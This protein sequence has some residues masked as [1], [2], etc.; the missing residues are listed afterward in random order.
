MHILFPYLHVP[1]LAPNR[2]HGTPPSLLSATLITPTT[3]HHN[4]H[5]QHNHHNNH[6]PNHDLISLLICC[7]DQRVSQKSVQS[8]S[9]TISSQS[10]TSTHPLANHNDTRADFQRERTTLIAAREKLDRFEQGEIKGL[11][12]QHH[13]CYSRKVRLGK[14][15]IWVTEGDRQPIQASQT[16]NLN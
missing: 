2:S 10:L 6:S 7:K 13:T 4:S 12:L 3:V 1:R 9:L 11:S 8:D 5:I 14:V 15:S 16:P